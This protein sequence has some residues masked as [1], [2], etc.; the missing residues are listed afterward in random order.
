MG[1]YVESD[2]SYCLSFK[3]RLITDGV[4]PGEP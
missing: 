1:S 3:E 2:F 4:S